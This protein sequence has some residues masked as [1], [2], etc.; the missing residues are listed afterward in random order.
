MRIVSLLVTLIWVPVVTAASSELKLVHM[1]GSAIQ[2]YKK[3]LCYQDTYDVQC[4]KDWF[5]PIRNTFS[6][7][8]PAFSSANN[9]TGQNTYPKVCCDVNP[10]DCNFTS[11]RDFDKIRDVCS[12]KT[13]CT[14]QRA[15]WHP[16]YAYK[17]NMN[18][19]YQQG[20]TTVLTTQYVTTEYMCVPYHSIQRMCE[21]GTKNGKGLFLASKHYP[22]YLPESTGFNCSCKLM[23]AANKVLQVAVIDLRLCSGSGGCGRSLNIGDT[24]VISVTNTKEEDPTLSDS[25]VGGIVGLKEIYSGASATGH[26]TMKLTDV[27]SKDALYLWLYL[28]AEGSDMTLTCNGET[29]FTTPTTTSTTAAPTT[30]TKPTTS[31]TPTTTPATTTTAATKQQSTNPGKINIYYSNSV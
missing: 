16:V 2:V 11:I 24:K 6:L 17:P 12:G 19:P 8:N 21:K 31:T 7:K 4:D 25:V 20:L 22:D 3:T 18:C 10:T 30:P 28:Y 1:N 26:V 23:F 27:D 29:T 5:A 14:G 15:P 13:H 9:C